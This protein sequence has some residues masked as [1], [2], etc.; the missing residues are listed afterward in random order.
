MPVILTQGQL[1]TLREENYQ[2]KEDFSKKQAGQW[3][4]LM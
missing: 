1:L 4:T 2:L 3:L